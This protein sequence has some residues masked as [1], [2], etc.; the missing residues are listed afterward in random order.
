MCKNKWLHTKDNYDNM[1]KKWGGYIMEEN[2]SNKNKKIPIIIAIV[3]AVI[4]IVGIVV[5][6]MILQNKDDE[7]DEISTGN[8]YGDATLKILDSEEIAK[9]EKVKLSFSDIDLDGVQELIVKYLGLKEEDE[10][11]PNQQI[12]IY[13]INDEKQ[14]VN[15][16]NVGVKEKN[17]NLDLAFAYNKVEEKYQWLE[18]VANDQKVSYYEIESQLSDSNEEDKKYEEGTKEF[19]ETFDKVDTEVSKEVEISGDLSKEELRDKIK[20]ALEGYIPTN[21]MIENKKELKISKLDESKDIVYTALK[22]GNYE[23]PVINID[24]QSIKSINAE[25][26]QK[27]GF[28]V[29]QIESGEMSFNE[30]EEI[31]Y[32][33]NVNDNILSLVLKRSGNDSTWCQVYNINLEDN[34][35]I[36]SNDLINKAGFERSQVIDKVTEVANQSFEKDINTAK[37]KFGNYWSTLEYDKELPKWKNNMQKDISELK[38]MY[39]N[40]VGN[41]C[42]IVHFQMPG[43]QWSCTHS[44]MINI[45][46]DYKVTPLTY[47]S[48]YEETSTTPTTEPTPVSSPSTKPS[49]VPSPKP[50]TA[51]SSKNSIADIK[52]SNSPSDKIAEGEYKRGE[53][54]TLTIT[55]S[56]A[57]SFDFKLY[58]TYMTSAGYPNFGL[59]EGTA[60]Q[61][62]DG[63]FAYVERKANGDDYDYNV[64][65]YIAGGDSN[66][67]ITIKDEDAEGWNPYCGH[68]VTFE[69]TFQK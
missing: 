15:K 7:K 66:T 12:K 5:A 33:Y 41:L 64:V 45:S 2:N 23:Y 9:Y 37:S 25:I 54:G 50:S 38:G 65:F 32:S 21:T 19:K 67:T 52:F 51:S 36:T 28:T 27:Y 48:A 49:P 31:S 18:K 29:Q 35:L 61:T 68:N 57:G 46:K 3:I 30:I 59:L 4:L 63:N 53:T 14:Y 47:K 26:K 62:T 42:M 13:K 40:D 43:G 39:L 56:K 8:E 11:K 69:G 60:K 17:S 16:V 20:E 6:V 58:C 24:D 55:N 34:S 1:Y 10:D 44:V 22:H